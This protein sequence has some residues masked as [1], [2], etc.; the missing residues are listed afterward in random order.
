ML[1][2]SVHVPFTRGSEIQLVSLCSDKLTTIM[3]S[4]LI[5]GAGISGLVLA[6]Y[7]RK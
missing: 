7:L 2:T 5:M 4:I 6:Q 1:C 3:E